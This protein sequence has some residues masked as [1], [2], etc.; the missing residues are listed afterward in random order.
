MKDRNIKNAISL[1]KYIELNVNVTSLIL[2]G[3]L[4]SLFPSITLLFKSHQLLYLV[5][6]P[7]VLFLPFILTSLI[8]KIA[9]KKATFRQILTASLLS[10]FVYSITLS[11]SI[12]ASSKATELT[13]LSLGFAISFL[14]WIGLSFLIFLNRFRGFAFSLLQLIIYAVFSYIAFSFSLNSLFVGFLI[15]T[16]TIGLV[17]FILVSILNAPMKKNFG[18]K[19]ID[20]ASGFLTHWFYGED[21]LE[22]LFLKVGKEVEVPVKLLLFKSDGVFGFVVPYIHFGPFGTLGGSSAPKVI[23]N[24]LGLTVLHGTATHDLN[25]TESKEVFKIVDEVKRRMSNLKWRE[26]KGYF[27]SVKDKARADAFAVNDAVIVGL[28]RAP[29]TTEDITFS[30][31]LLLMEMLKPRFKNPIVFDEHNSG[32]SKI[33]FFD[34][35]SDEF[36]EYKN[37]VRKLLNKKFTPVRLRGGF[38]RLNIEHPQ[39]GG[40][41]IQILVFE[42]NKKIAYII[43]DANGVTEK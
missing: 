40:A 38:T 27:L 33:T 30:A 6:G 36:L 7:F 5:Y 19:S 12:I 23:S 10:A 1:T 26:A 42:A 21:F 16:F 35:L 24:E 9:F 34:V 13:F 25:P 22:E 31:G 18:V 4:V 41:G 39:V 15:A 28:T 8:G 14:M 20:V 32:G 17:S 29:D 11:I 2:A 37:V 3:F 43:I